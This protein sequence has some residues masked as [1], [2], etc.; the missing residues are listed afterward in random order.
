M[1]LYNTLFFI[2]LSHLESVCHNVQPSI[3][4]INR[5]YKTRIPS[6]ELNGKVAVASN[7][8]THTPIIMI[9]M[10]SAS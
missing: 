4:K 2:Y 8:L 9:T 6:H 5:P 3:R 1:H 7:I 10:S